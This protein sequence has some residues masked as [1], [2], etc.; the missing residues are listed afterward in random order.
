MAGGKIRLTAG[1]SLRARCTST[2][3]AAGAHGKAAV[4]KIAIA[5]CSGLPNVERS[6]KT[7][8]PSQ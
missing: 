4:A 8:P 1:V 3:A 6:F 7:G 2:C 5:A